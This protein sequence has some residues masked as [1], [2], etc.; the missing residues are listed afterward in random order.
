MADTETSK[1]GRYWAI[2][3]DGRGEV[4]RKQL[5][6][7][8]QSGVQQRGL[9]NRI[10]R[11]AVMGG[12]EKGAPGPFTQESQQAP[13]AGRPVFPRFALTCPNGTS[14]FGTGRKR[15]CFSFRTMLLRG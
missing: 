6:K 1:T 10:M 15:L 5:G 12:V 14:P 11:F 8:L 3:G 9:M 7:E 2:G 4:E 13:S